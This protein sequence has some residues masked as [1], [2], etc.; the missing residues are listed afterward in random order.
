MTTKNKTKKERKEVRK[1]MQKVTDV[2]RSRKAQQWMVGV[3]FAVVH[4]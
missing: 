3:L 2:M 1:G 4:Q